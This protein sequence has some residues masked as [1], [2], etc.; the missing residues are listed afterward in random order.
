MEKKRGRPPKKDYNPQEL[1]E[2]PTAIVS[3]TYAQI[4]EIKATA[5]ELKLPPHKISICYGSSAE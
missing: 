5:T 3:E 4:N 2:A 1:M